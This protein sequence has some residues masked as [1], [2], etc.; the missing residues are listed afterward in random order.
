MEL[1]REELQ[2]FIQGGSAGRPVRNLQWHWCWP[3]A[4]LSARYQRRRTV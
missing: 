3:D 4:I 2:Q 1:A